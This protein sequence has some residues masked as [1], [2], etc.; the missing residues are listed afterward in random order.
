M[1]DDFLSFAKKVGEDVGNILKGFRPSKERILTADEDLNTVLDRGV[2]NATY[3]MVD[4]EAQNYPGN[5]KGY[6][7]VDT[8]EAV[9]YITQYFYSRSNLNVPYIAYRFMVTAGWSPWVVVHPTPTEIRQDT[10]VGTRV[11][12]ED[13]MIYGDTGWRD[14][15]AEVSDRESGRL[16]IRR[17]GNQVFLVTDALKLT[18]T[19]SVTLPRLNGSFYPIS[20]IRGPWNESLS[21]DTAK[22]SYNISRTGYFNVYS[23]GSGEIEINATFLTDNSWP[24]SLPGTPS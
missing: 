15:S 2:Y 6:V 8:M 12:V 13:T 21:S 7:V 19:G 9:N 3:N 10:S 16:L 17:I 24:S 20:R 23:V 14:I 5:L 4:W 1:S 22:G 18:S 11:F